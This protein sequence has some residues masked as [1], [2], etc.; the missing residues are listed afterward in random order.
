[1]AKHYRIV[2]QSFESEHPDIILTERTLLE[3]TLN[4]PTNCFDFAMDHSKQ[5]ALIQAAQ[6]SVLNEKSNL[7]HQSQ[8]ICPDC[9]KKLMKFGYQTSTF[10]DVLTDHKVKI[11]RLKCHDCG[12]EVKATVRTFLGT[13]QSGD[14]KKIQA[15]LGAN[16]TYRESE[17]LLG[18][19]S[20]ADRVI[21][22]HD[23]VKH[24]TESV[25]TIVATISETEKAIMTT[26]EAKELILSVDG[27]HIHTIEDKRSIEAIAS[28]VYRPDA[29]VSNPKGTLHYLKS[30]NCAAS[31]NDDNQEQ[32]ISGTIIAALRQG[33]TE[34][35]HIT[36][37]CDGAANCWQVV[38][39]LKPLCAE[40]TCILDWF[41]LAMKIQNISLPERLK[42]KLLRIKWHLWRGNVAHA[43]LRLEQLMKIVQDEKQFERIKKFK[44]YVV[45]NKQRIVNY[46]ARQKNGLVFTSSLAESTV[47]S[48]INRRCKGQQHM[49]WSRG[50]L[51]PLLQLRAAIQSKND[52]SKKWKMAVLNA[53]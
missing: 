5:I 37:L 1:M 36:A 44:E 3:D 22:N 26:E 31:V 21:N 25:G 14:L 41:H 50:G 16:F 13:T 47:E 38:D 48:L 49:R 39:A 11:Q 12:Y 30:K 6:D 34:N 40:M 33:L 10:H 18:L 27:G 46:R 17:Q 43:L 4:I 2:F 7:I 53:T 28:V 20:N 15:T 51:N 24:V 23:R 29:L 19:F 32:I 8:K 45:N 42:T 9:Q 52:W 35:T